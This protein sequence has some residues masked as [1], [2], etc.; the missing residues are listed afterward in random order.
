MYDVRLSFDFTWDRIFVYNEYRAISA[1]KN[2]DGYD[3]RINLDD[4]FSQFKPSTLAGKKIHLKVE[5]EG[6]GSA[7]GA[8]NSVFKTYIND[9][10]VMT[11]TSR[12]Q[13]KGLHCGF[14][15]FHERNESQTAYADNLKVTDADGNIVMEE[16]FS[17]PCD[18]VFGEQFVDVVKGDEV[19][20]ADDEFVTEE[21]DNGWLRINGCTIATPTAYS[22]EV[23][24]MFRKEFSADKGAV[25]SARLYTSAAICRRG[26]DFPGELP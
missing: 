18:T 3:E 9:T 23:A 10:L 19:Y 6:P 4:K 1:T 24:P 12:R 17:D 2:K 25:K 16:D 7:E 11:H 8:E 5:V 14:G 22:D 15:F 26:E 20:Y 13:A 21:K